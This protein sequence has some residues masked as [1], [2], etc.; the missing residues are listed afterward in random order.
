MA[1]IGDASKARILAF[2]ID[3]L[4]AFITSILAVSITDSDSGMVRAT[5]M[6]GM[7]LLYY[8]VLESLW[9]RTPGKFFQGLV[10]RRIDGTK[11][12]LKEHFIRTLAR[13]FEVNPILF[14]GL[15]AGI[16]ILSSERKQRLGDLLAGTL[17]ISRELAP[18]LK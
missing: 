17:V 7:Y 13:I 16:A 2:F 10:I 1:L 11:C 8:F 3:N 4:L 18:P 12:G 15:P 14:G 5:L 6:C 9:A